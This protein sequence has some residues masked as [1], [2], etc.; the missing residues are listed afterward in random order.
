MPI[1][2]GWGKWVGHDRERGVDLPPF[3]VS[4]SSLTF[5]FSMWICTKMAREQVRVDPEVSGEGLTN[6]TSLTRPVVPRHD[7]HPASLEWKSSANPA[8]IYLNV[9]FS[10]F[11][12]FIFF[13][14]KY[15]PGCGGSRGIQ[16][17]SISYKIIWIISFFPWKMALEYEIVA[18]GF[19]LTVILVINFFLFPFQRNNLFW[20]IQTSIVMHKLLHFLWK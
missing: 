18:A 5:K 20:K 4:S 2:I 19:Q 7:P 8:V 14:M 9:S 17:Y 12:S 1:R 6:G 15:L 10:T 13:F 3:S 16:K 11:H